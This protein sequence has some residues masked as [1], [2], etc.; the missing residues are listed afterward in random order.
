MDEKTIA[1]LA[2]DVV[3]LQEHEDK[4]EDLQDGNRFLRNLL[5]T[6]PETAKRKILPF[7]N[8][9]ASIMFGPLMIEIGEPQ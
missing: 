1:K 3:R 2:R 8:V 9:H 6:A 5:V 4:R 7:G